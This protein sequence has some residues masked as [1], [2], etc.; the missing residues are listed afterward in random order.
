[1]T[2]ELLF[3]MTAEQA[4]GFADRMRGF[5][6]GRISSERFL[7]IGVGGAGWIYTRARPRCGGA[8]VED[9]RMNGRRRAAIR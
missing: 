8:C 4:Q 7:G 5:D 2:R 3:L 6:I 9:R 1:M